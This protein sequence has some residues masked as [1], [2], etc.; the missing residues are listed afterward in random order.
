MFD[1]AKATY[2]DLPFYYR[3]AMTRDEIREVFVFVGEKCP[4]LFQEFYCL[5]ID[6]LEAQ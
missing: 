4:E 3:K 5:N 1:F 6:S 2:N